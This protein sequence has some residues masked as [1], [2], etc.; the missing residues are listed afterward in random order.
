MAEEDF[1]K[2]QEIEACGTGRGPAALLRGGAGTGE[3]WLLV[4]ASDGDRRP[5]ARPSGLRGGDLLLFEPGVEPDLSGLAAP[6][7]A[8]EWIRFIPRPGWLRHMSAWPRFRGRTRMVRFPAGASSARIATAFRRC[9]DDLRARSSPYDRELALNALGEIVYLGRREVFLRTGLQELSPD[10]RRV[11]QILEARMTSPYT[12][13]SLARLANLS[14]SRFAHR[15]KTE[16]GQS[17]ISFLNRMRLL[18]AV[19]VLAFTKRSLKEVARD[20]GFASQ[21]YFGRQFRRL[22]GTS[23]GEYRRRFA[24]GGSVL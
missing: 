13:L 23:P 8:F 16:T 14:P 4:R 18:R 11:V 7:L 19:R 15:F 12:I 9:M 17:V 20:A 22:F 24:A 21:G 10:I 6:N 1:F 5:P 2:R 3:A